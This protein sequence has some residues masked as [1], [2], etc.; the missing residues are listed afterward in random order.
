[1]RPSK[2]DELVQSALKVFYLNGFAATGMD[3]LVKETGVSKTSMYKYFRTKDD[4]ILA[5]L[6]L[7]DEQFRNRIFR[8]VEELAKT[9]LEQV[10]ALFDVLQEWFDDSD[11]QGCMFIKAAAEFQQA[12]HPIY[13]QSAEHKKI[14]FGTV[15]KMV[16]QLN[17]ADPERLTRQLMLLKEGAIVVTHMRG[18][19]SAASDAKFAAFALLREAGVDLSGVSVS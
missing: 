13:A 18:S 16:S 1:M 7:R 4:L 3:M 5:V 12:E 9:P 17:V 6:R 8:R 19:E 2:R 10:L 14:F 11:F 15:L